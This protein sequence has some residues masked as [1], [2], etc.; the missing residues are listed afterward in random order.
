MYRFSMKP[1]RKPGGALLVSG[2]IVEITHGMKA[3]I[4]KTLNDLSEQVQSNEGEVKLVFPI[5]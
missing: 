2:R 5:S 4:G 3:L 1:L